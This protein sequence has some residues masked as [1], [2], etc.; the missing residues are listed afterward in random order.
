ML[1]VRGRAGNPF[2][3]M[4]RAFPCISR[5][6]VTIAD[7]RLHLNISIDSLFPLKIHTKHVCYAHGSM[8]SI[9]CDVT[10]GSLFG[11]RRRQPWTGM[12]MEIIV[13]SM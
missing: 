12:T 3:H 13:L 9:R 8:S 6:R 1:T 10:Y 11:F 2:G 5:G 7:G 4:T